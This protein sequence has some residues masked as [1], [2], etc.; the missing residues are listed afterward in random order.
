MTRYRTG[1][2]FE[3]KLKQDLE[4]DGFTVLRSAGSHGIFDLIGLKLLPRSN[5]VIVRCIQCKV[6]SSSNIKALKKEF[7]T[8]APFEA[9]T[10]II[11]QQLAVKTKG[12]K[13]YDLYTLAECKE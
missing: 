4:A 2:T 7:V 11:E 6:T 9:E 10:A 1:R 5:R 3:Y 13:N 12:H 8:S